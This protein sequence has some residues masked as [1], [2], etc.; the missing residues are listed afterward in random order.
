MI[1]EFFEKNLD[2]KEMMRR[3]SSVTTHRMDRMIIDSIPPITSRSNIGSILIGIASFFQQE[4]SIVQLALPPSPE[5][6]SSVQLPEY[7]PTE[8]E[9]RNI[10]FF[11]KKTKKSMF[12]Y[13][14]SRPDLCRKAVSQIPFRNF[15]S[16]KR[17]NFYIQLLQIAFYSDSID[18][19][20]LVIVDTPSP[21]IKSLRKTHTGSLIQF[22]DHTNKIP[23]F[24][25]EQ[26]SQIASN[27]HSLNDVPTATAFAASPT[28]LF[29]GKEG[30][31]I[32]ILSINS[33]NMKTPH[34]CLFRPTVSNEAYSLAWIKG[35]LWIL[36]TTT[37]WQVNTL[38]P[39]VWTFINNK[40]RDLVPPM[41]TDG[42]FFYCV[43]FKNRNPEIHIFSFNGTDFIPERHIKLNNQITS[44]QP[45]HR[46]PFAT[47]GGLICFAVV[48]G[49]D[50][51]FKTFSLANG[52]LVSDKW[53]E[54]SLPTI[55]CWCTRP[56]S[57][58][59]IILTPTHINIYNKQ[60]QIP[61][62]LLGLPWPRGNDSNPVLNALELANF[63]GANFFQSSKNIRDLDP[64]LSYYASINS[65]IGFRIVAQILLRSNTSHLKQAL[66]TVAEYYNK[67]E[68]NLYMQR[69]CCFIYLAC[70][71]ENPIHVKPNILSLYIENDNL[72]LDFIFLYPKAISF[73]NT[74]LSEIAIKK[75]IVYVAE[76]WND[77][78]IEASY[79]ILG[80]L[81]DYAAIKM[82]EN[83]Y[84]SILEPVTAIF[85]VITK[86][87]SLVFKNKYSPEAFIN[88][89]Q[90]TAWEFLIKCI[91]NA[92][93]SWPKYAHILVRML[94]VAFYDQH[95]DVND[96]EKI[97]DMMNKT[98]LLLTELVLAVPMKLYDVTYKTLNKLYEDYPH[99]LKDQY[100][101]VDRAVLNLMN[102]AY[103][104]S[105]PDE[106]AKY[107][108]KIRRTIIFEH[109]CDVHIINNIK[110]SNISAQGVLDFL[111]TK[112]KN[113]SKLMPV[114]DSSIIHWFFS[115]F[116]K[117]YNKLTVDQTVI[118][119][120]FFQKMSNRFNQYSIDIFSKKEWDF[121]SHF[122]FPYLFSP[123][124][125][126]QTGKTLPADSIILLK[127]D[128]L[129]HSFNTIHKVYSLIDEPKKLLEPF[130]KYLPPN[131]NKPKY[132]NFA[133]IESEPERYKAVLLWLIPATSGMNLD[134]SKYIEAY[135]LY[136]W[137]GSPRIVESIMKGI[138]IAEKRTQS[139]LNSFYK[140]ILSLV[141]NYIAKFHS[142]F[143]MQ[144][145]QSDTITS[146]F[147]IIQYLKKMFSSKS[148]SFRYYIEE[149]SK[150]CKPSKAAAIFAILNNS[151]ETIRKGVEIHFY[152]SELIEIS[153]IVEDYFDNIIR[154]DGV[155]YTLKTCTKI[156]CKCT[157]KVHLS[158][159]ED[160]KV[161]AA[162]FERTKFN[163]NT[164]A[165]LN[166][167]K[168]ASLISFLKQKK[169]HKLLSHSFKNSITKLPSPNF[170]QPEIYL[171]EFFSYLSPDTMKL[172][173]INFVNIEEFNTEQ[174]VSPIVQ[175]CLLNNVDFSDK[176]EGM[177]MTMEH[178]SK[179]VSS[180]IHTL[181]EMT[182]TFTLLPS[183]APKDKSSLILTVFGISRNSS[184]VLKSDNF[185]VTS[186]LIEPVVIELKLTPKNAIFSLYINNKL[187]S[188]TA[189]SPSLNM[190]Y[191]TI[192]LLPSMILEYRVDYIDNIQMIETLPKCFNLVESNAKLMKIARPPIIV[193]VTD[194]SIYNR[195]CL[196]QSAKCISECFSQIITMQ[197]LLFALRKQKP[198]ENLIMRVLCSCNAFPNEEI[199]D[200]TNFRVSHL[201]DNLGSS[202][203]SFV[204]SIFQNI[205][206]IN[207]DLYI[208]AVDQLTEPYTNS[209]VLPSNK[210]VV[211]IR[212]NQSFPVSNCYV[213]SAEAPPESIGFSTGLHETNSSTAVIP[214][215]NFHGTIIDCLIYLRH[216]LALFSFTKNYN[217]SSIYRIIDK[218]TI[219]NPSFKSLFAPIIELMELIFPG[220][221]FKNDA[222]FLIKESIV[223]EKQYEY[224]IPHFASSV[225]TPHV[226]QVS[227][228][229][230]FKVPN[231]DLVYLTVKVNS[232][233][234]FNIIIKESN[235]EQI[236]ISTDMFIVLEQ[237]EFSIKAEDKQ[238]EKASIE[239]HT[240]PINSSL[241]PINLDK[242]K[243]NHSHQ[244]YCSLGPDQHLTPEMYNLM[245]LST[246]FPYHVSLFVLSVIRNGRSSLF[247]FNSHI[248]QPTQ[249]RSRVTFSRPTN[250]LSNSDDFY[251][252]SED[253]PSSYKYCNLVADESLQ[254]SQR[255]KYLKENKLTTMALIDPDWIRVGP[256]ISQY[257]GSIRLLKQHLEKNIK[258]SKG[259]QVVAEWLQNYVQKMS[260]Y[261]LLMFI[262]FVIGRWGTRA[263]QSEVPDSIYV[264][265]SYNPEL[266]ETIQDE[267]LII[268]GK[269]PNEQ[270]FRYRLMVAIQEYNDLQFNS[271]V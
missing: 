268:I 169:F 246:L 242:W 176:T 42:Q 266:I 66:K 267:N 171:S 115:E 9:L 269:F 148:G 99:P 51:N 8:E 52:K 149:I 164:E 72:D 101:I 14:A 210:S 137:S 252:P 183:E 197:I 146:L 120:I 160:F 163:S 231:A 36:T 17:K 103:D 206:D 185:K 30:G 114:Q 195:C 237:N 5:Y 49:K 113:T 223:L 259:A 57:N 24:Y 245:P 194:S 112:G 21:P 229:A 243:T 263:L 265:H 188:Q 37:I 23:G 239:I 87:V 271:A 11:K 69:F 141:S 260:S 140:Y 216:L 110:Y 128:I 151:L 249:Q 61:R 85:R 12:K 68:S 225:I 75:L 232:P 155:Q 7:T 60:L 251:S 235:S 107:F 124:M 13:L 238:Y 47:D 209:I 67:S 226:W 132:A 88:S 204:L 187:D 123:A 172:P 64:L 77:F 247:R 166:V 41:C 82:R 55:T 156:W 38:I 127:P 220:N 230:D 258:Y 150:Y 43:R 165:H 208:Q 218:L 90:Y 89:S 244:I 211:F 79:I 224:L 98:L 46:I 215:S 108:F 53:T 144:T 207:L 118:L 178:E 174:Q 136:I 184:L 152:S 91:M 78:P 83:T 100:P 44:F 175:N 159:I 35:Y 173:P 102:K 254:S 240:Y 189:V 142:Y 15:K 31:F 153:G 200:F 222:A 116:S 221:T 161:Y 199:L 255:I 105:T 70:L 134:F 125:I 74:T 27:E 205:D 117:A 45:E 139:N 121:E 26:S 32:R 58:E 253:S 154:V 202:F 84:D 106:Y 241:I 182:L 93:Q 34:Y 147:I 162:L 138:V 1:C 92:H 227:L 213:F 158:V 270:V 168:Y 167:F 179:F 126:R 198:K 257:S 20:K 19:F 94:K 56:F 248:V 131:T 228:P 2:D 18:L 6:F 109:N 130:V 170:F 177:L 97:R 250:I 25:I 22:I 196:Q 261:V 28:E 157:Q 76:H 71:N 181:C 119:S 39:K 86:T 54:N 135:K 59:H 10:K 50:T 212:N 95:Q 143:V 65:D 29:I 233:T 111:Q 236:I 81:E 129:C 3:R 193:P 192:D 73:R 80:F 145:E 234:P 4:N 201:F 219:N 133:S 16:N 217:F 104:V 256:E 40:P 122:S 96:C 33:D 63:H 191:I 190:L 262:D 214:F 186:D 62:W 264:D 180:P 203:V 48:K